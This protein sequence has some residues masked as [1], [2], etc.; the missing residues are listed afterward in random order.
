MIKV[1]DNIKDAEKLCSEIHLHLQKNCPGYNAVIWQIPVKDEK[2][3][4]YFVQLPKE[5]EKQTYQS[6]DK[7]DIVL[8]PVTDKTVLTVSKFPDRETE[9]STV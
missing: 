1:F 9:I 7:I 8:K 3:E 4:L 5:F 6:V 2:Q